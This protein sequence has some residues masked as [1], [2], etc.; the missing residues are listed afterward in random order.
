MTTET[1]TSQVPESQTTPA[2]SDTNAAA[3]TCKFELS[4]LDFCGQPIK[5]ITYRVTVGD[6]VIDGTTDA[7]GKAADMGALPFGEEAKIEVKTD[8]GA[9]K[10][11]GAVLLDSPLTTSTAISPKVL[12]ETEP[13]QLHEGAAGAAEQS[14]PKIKKDEDVVAIDAPQKAS[15]SQQATPDKASSNPPKEKKID[16]NPPVMPKPTFKT[17][18]DKNGSPFSVLE[19]KLG[20]WYE[21]AS[22]AATA[23]IHWLWSWADFDKSKQGQPTTGSIK[24]KTPPNNAALVKKLIEVATENASI[25]IPETSAA[26]LA[27]MANG[28][29]DRAKHVK[30]AR[31]SEDGL[32]AKYVN[33]ALCESGVTNGV[34]DMPYATL[35]GP[36]LLAKG[37]TDVT[38][39]LPD[40][41][42][43][44]TGDVIVYKWTDTTWVN[45]RKKY[46]NDNVPNYG[47]IHIRSEESYISDGLPRRHHPE[48]S[49]YI[50]TGIYRK[51]F[52]LMPTLRIKAFLACLR[53]FEGQAE[54]DDGKR[55]TLLNSPLPYMV[56]GKHFDRGFAEHPWAKVFEHVQKGKSTASG[57]YQILLSTWQ[58]FFEGGLNGQPPIQI[59]APKGA[60]KFSPAIQDRLA[61]IIIE[62]AKPKANINVLG[63]VRAGRLQ[64][65]VSHLVTIW[66]SLPGGAENAN[67]RTGDNKPMDMSYLQALFNN[68][69]EKEKRK[70]NAI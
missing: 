33:I 26:A 1:Q 61:V 18:R 39:E 12:I 56:S 30:K 55:Y 46:K 51:V 5:G 2:T 24:L 38:A 64:E 60:D 62:N 6:K 37:F 70:I 42:W 28:Q 53:E 9:Y 67:R 65:A 59:T 68:F 21:E 52:D 14:I 8:A 66:T 16:R 43:A 3:S 20:S 69:L 4:Y 27:A 44:A 29:F 10:E 32:C 54:H 22:V 17:G 57:A 11:I 7:E 15:T 41:R 47:H 50:V 40:A 49:E 13:T 58:Q 63:M 35:A 31:P 45:R 36:Q 25:H 19:Y 48:W 34:L 23:G